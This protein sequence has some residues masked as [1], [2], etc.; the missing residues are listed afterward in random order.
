MAKVEN[1][2][3]LKENTERH[4]LETQLPRCE[5]IAIE[6]L[7]EWTGSA[8]DDAETMAG[9][10][11]LG[12]Q[13]EAHLNDYLNDAILLRES[14]QAEA[15]LRLLDQA[16]Q[17][18]GSSVWIEDNCARAQLALNDPAL[19][20]VYWEQAFELAE[21]DEERAFVISE[22]QQ[23]Y[24]QLSDS[25][26]E[27][28]TSFKTSLNWPDLIQVL[29]V[30]LDNQPHN[31]YL[32]LE[33]AIA[34]RE[35]GHF[36]A[37]LQILDA[38]EMSGLESLWIIDN[39]VRLLFNK[40][41]Y[42]RAV[43][44]AQRLMAH[45]DYQAHREQLDPLIAQCVQRLKQ[46][47]RK[48]DSLLA[49]IDLIDDSGLFDERYYIKQLSTGLLNYANA[50][51]HF[52]RQ[53]WRDDRRPNPFFEPQ[54]YHQTHGLP[55][56][57]NPLIHYIC[58]GINA[59]LSPGRQFYA[60]DYWQRQGEAM[61]VAGIG[62]PLRHYLTLH[63]ADQPALESVPISYQQSL[64]SLLDQADRGQET[65]LL[66]T[67][68]IGQQIAQL[69]LDD[70][71]HRLLRHFPLHFFLRYGEDYALSPN[72]LFDLAYIAKRF[73]C[74]LAH[75]YRR[76]MAALELDPRCSPHPLFDADYYQLQLDFRGIEVK[77]PLVSHYLREGWLI[78][79]DPHPLF[80]SEYYRNH[81]QIS[82]FTVCPLQHYLLNTHR[83]SGDASPFVDDK[84]YNH[85]R[86]EVGREKCGDTPL[87]DLVLQTQWVD[88][89]PDISPQSIG[90]LIETVGLTEIELRDRRIVATDFVAL[91]RE[92]R[93]WAY[94]QPT[95]SMDE[96]STERPE[97]S[98][99]VLNY[100]KLVHSIL[101]SFCA[102][103]ALQAIP[104]E[105]IVVDN[106]S[107]FFL[108]KNLA[109]YLNPLPDCRV[110]RLERNRFFGEG[111]NIALDQAKGR[112]V[113]FLNNDAYVSGDTF[114]KMR[115]VFD[116]QHDV[117]AVGPILVLP[118][119]SLQ[120]VGGKVSGCGQFIQIGKHT[121]I[122]PGLIQSLA[123][124]PHFADY[125]SAACCMIDHRV[126]KQVGGFDYLYE[127]FYY[128]DTDLF[129]RI[130][131]AGYQLYIEHGT[132]AVHFE[133]TSTRNFMGEGWHKLIDTNRNKFFKRWFGK[134]EQGAD[135]GE[136]TP[137]L[138]LYITPPLARVNRPQAFLYSP[139][140]LG[141][142]GGE[143]YLLT[144][145]AVVAERYQ[146]TLV[147][148]ELNSIHRL[149]M[150][151]EDLN[152]SADGLSIL[153]WNEA[154]RRPK[155]DLWIVMGNEIVPSVPAIGQHNL[156]HCQFPFPLDFMVRPDA[157]QSLEGYSAFIVNSRFTRDEVARQLLLYGLPAL[158]IHVISPPCWD[159]DLEA[160]LRA[161][162]VKPTWRRARGL[163][164]LNVGRFFR[165][166]HNKRQ[167]IVLDVVERLRAA[168]RAQGWDID[169][170]L[171][172]G[173][174]K[175]EEDYYNGLVLRAKSLDVRLASNVEFSEIEAAYQEADCYL[176]AAGFGRPEGF[177][178]HELEHFGITVVEA[179]VRGVIPLVYK[180]GGPYEIVRDV[181][182]GELYE[183]VD[184]AVEAIWQ[185]VDQ[186]EGKIA[187][188][189]EAMVR[190]CLG[191]SIQVFRQKIERI[192]ELAV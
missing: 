175:S 184:G 23:L 102:H 40:E 120:E 68:Y 141:P 62:D 161:I 1:V 114:V 61:S 25:I 150:V 126:L 160:R 177:S 164:L 165:H 51:V 123:H 80:D 20:A 163:S 110:L 39:R 4:M 47:R 146:T 65:H 115:A 11:Q 84:F 75:A 100:N 171:L 135:L 130:R 89:H 9:Y 86:T 107:D 148:P 140:P 87:H 127:P 93:T 6:S 83:F 76:F 169:A 64:T 26:R 162:Q 125:C 81:L 103:R 71:Q 145:A 187:E 180:A 56:D 104:H 27:Q 21:R 59:R 28:I 116:H 181:G 112:Y 99:I 136:A 43:Q 128:E 124:M 74:P 35:Q 139:F 119:Y 149:K 192:V 166:G 95:A 48:P 54:W 190:G 113:A 36:D 108:Y 7:G 63:K 37:A 143:K 94:R 129:S 2:N 44:E 31:L 105:L 38:A 109:R 122:G 90:Q 151:A 24:P 189:R 70:S 157:L 167:D 22:L 118:N 41:L 85:K 46:E 173:V 172:G 79:L 45:V 111:N 117:A 106:G 5:E 8:T 50:I 15:S 58:I 33:L 19:A 142:G 176:H 188:M 121:K 158:P 18:F 97:L 82:H 14:G 69:D 170:T 154:L 98:V 96:L 178:P 42:S 138:S 153:S 91:V 55:E 137:R 52:L 132:H 168:R 17:R 182:V 34:Y 186:P 10:R 78:G 57:V 60:E 67:A 147:F 16:R 174:S 88:F 144:L 131:C 134:L 30:A 152:V 13:G 66:D 185:L 49:Y 73:D 53:G 29:R 32:H 191:Y 77:Q 159:G 133:N 101:S 183:S 155:P 156:Y 179:M 92:L 3:R 72:P 12:D